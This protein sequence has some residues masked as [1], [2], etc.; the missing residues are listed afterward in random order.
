M[1]HMKVTVLSGLCDGEKICLHVPC[2]LAPGT[3][4]LISI[5]PDDTFQKE[6]EE[7]FAVSK[8]ALARVYGEGEP[9][10]SDY[11]CRFPPE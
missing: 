6:R 9:D 5:L 2:D 7:W 1:Q 11:V 10:Y 3:P 4:L 8:A